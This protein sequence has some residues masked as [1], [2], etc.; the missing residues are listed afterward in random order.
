[1]RDT[2][3]HAI[4]TRDIRD[5]CALV[6]AIRALV[7]AI[8]ALVHAIRALVHAIRALV[9]AIRA[10]VHAIRDTYVHALVH[11]MIRA[12]VHAIRALV[13]PCDTYASRY[14]RDPCVR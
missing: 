11:A 8:R 5:T 6:H 13:H 4:R 12:L 10:L 3:V 7:H 2:L 14:M 1:M 9:H